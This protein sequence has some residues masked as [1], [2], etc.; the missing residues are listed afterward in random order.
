[1]V[2]LRG[3]RR[4]LLVCLIALARASLLIL[5][6]PAR[7]Q[8]DEI[9]RKV[10]TSVQPAYPELARR[11]NIVGVVRVQL[12]VAPNGSVKSMK[13]IGGH[14]VLATAVMDAVKK[15]RFQEASEET[16]GVVQFKF[17]RHQ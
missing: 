8:Q 1:M 2:Y 12:V 16:T 17:D 13:V 7:A 3:R 15:W 6:A 10:K 14:P 9:T 4:W 5:P 11:M